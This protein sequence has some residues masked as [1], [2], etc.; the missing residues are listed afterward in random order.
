[1][2]SLRDSHPECTVLWLEHLI[3]P[4]NNP[5][6]VFKHKTLHT[7]HIL[8]LGLHLARRLASDVWRRLLVDNHA[9]CFG[10]ALNGL[11]LNSVDEV[12]ASGDVVD[13]TDDLTGCPDL[14]F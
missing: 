13:E 5:G 11:L 6:G 9:L 8:Q 12:F 10:Q 14:F 4:N 2:L 7:S 3:H 1:M